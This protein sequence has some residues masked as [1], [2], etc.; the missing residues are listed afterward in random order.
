[1]LFT[2]HPAE[3]SI[4]M[5]VTINNIALPTYKK[6]YIL[7]KYEYLE[8][9]YIVALQQQRPSTLIAICLQLS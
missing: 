1:M 6:I 4:K 9:E 8:K 2:L 7:L 5:R 3:Q